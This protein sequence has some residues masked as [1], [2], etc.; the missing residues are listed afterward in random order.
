ME[1][2]LKQ[3]CPNTCHLKLKGLCQ[4]GWFEIRSL[5]TFGELYEHHVIACLDA[6]VNPHAYPEFNESR[7]NW[8]SNTKTTAHDLKS[9]L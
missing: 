1:L 7:W 5:K 6:V 3:Y 9:S 2:A 4:T 8:D